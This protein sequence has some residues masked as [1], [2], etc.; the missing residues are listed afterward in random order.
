MKPHYW[1]VSAG[2]VLGLVVALCS[3]CQADNNKNPALTTKPST[4]PARNV[5]LLPVL[6]TDRG[7]GFFKSG[8]VDFSGKVVIPLKFSWCG[9][10]YR[11]FARVNAGT[12]FKPKYGFINTKGEFVIPPKFDAVGEFGQDGDSGTYDHQGLAQVLID[13]KWGYIDLAGKI[14]IEPK[15][16]MAA[17]FCGGMAGVVLGGKLGFIDKTGKMVIEPQFN[18]SNS[19]YPFRNGTALVAVG[20]R[21]EGPGFVGQKMGII[22][23]SG[24]FVIEA[25]YDELVEFQDEDITNVCLDGKWGFIDRR[26]DVAIPLQYSR[27][28]RFSKGMAAVLDPKTGKWG[29]IDKKGDYVIVPRFDDIAP[30]FYLSGIFPC[31][32]SEELMPVCPDRKTGLWGYIDRKGNDVIAPRFCSAGNFCCG[33]APVQVDANGKYGFADKTGKIVIEPKYDDAPGFSKSGVAFV[34]VGRSYILIDKTGKVLWEPP[35]E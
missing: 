28:Y 2:I 26:G 20:G 24:K 8:Y 9:P 35:A 22:D 32:W 19:I 11:G 17:P 10:F 23:K 1:F 14:V 21:R 30:G 12:P 7:S 3:F 15:F 5:E 29:F 13:G 27:A 4:E 16:E 18:H 6:C 25:K 31:A 34:K 33:L